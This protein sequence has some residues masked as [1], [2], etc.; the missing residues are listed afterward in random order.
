M[1]HGQSIGRRHG[2]DD[3]GHAH[4]LTFTCYRRHRFLAAERTCRWLADSIAEARVRHRFDLWAF[5]FMPEHAHLIIRP[6]APESTVAAILKGIKQPVGRRALLFIEAEA[7]HWLPRVTRQRGGRVERLFWQ[8]GGGYDRNIVEPRVLMAMIDYVH[9]NPIRRGLAKRAGD[10]SW[11][12][13][14]WYEGTPRNELRPD[15]IPPEWSDV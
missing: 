10:W 6:H 3:P 4:A 7:P 11:S 14:G 8:S 9:A 15:P 12:S 13:A 1:D 5:V 2:F